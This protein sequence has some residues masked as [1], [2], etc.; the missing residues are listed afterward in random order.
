MYRFQV[1]TRLPR[2]SRLFLRLAE[3]GS[4][5]GIIVRR[6]SLKT[7]RGV[8]TLVV[9]GVNPRLRLRLVC[10]S[11]W[12]EKKR[13]E[14]EKLGLASRETVGAATGWLRPRR[15]VVVEA[16]MGLRGWQ[17]VDDDGRY[18][19][20]ARRRRE[21]RYGDAGGGG[22]RDRGRRRWRWRRGHEQGHRTR[23]VRVRTRWRLCHGE[24]LGAARRRRLEAARIAGDGDG[25]RQR[26]RIA[27]V[28]DYPWGSHGCLDLRELRVLDRCGAWRRDVRLG[29]KLGYRVT[30]DRHITGTRGTHNRCTRN[31]RGCV[32]RLE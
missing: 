11:Q 22:R 1:G 9:G 27:R 18:H 25:R 3:F 32:C 26:Q 20:L 29:W 5:I 15:R 21:A 4:L 23:R 10:T 7:V 17:R 30:D 12:N 8:T 24:L 13:G 6:L 31:S 14:G 16:L 28:R 2:G 19:R